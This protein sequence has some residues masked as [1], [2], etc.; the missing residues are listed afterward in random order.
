MADRLRRRPASSNHFGPTATDA[1]CRPRAGPR[2]S[3][4]NEDTMVMKARVSQWRIARRCEKR[5]DKRADGRVDLK[6]F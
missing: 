3:K 2:A 1:L 4:A 5:F 6:M